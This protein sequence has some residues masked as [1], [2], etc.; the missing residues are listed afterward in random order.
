MPTW[1]KALTS[2]L[3]RKD[4]AKPLE[5]WTRDKFQCFINEEPKLADLT[6]GELRAIFLRHYGRYD[7]RDYFKRA[8][9]LYAW[10]KYYRDTPPVYELAL[11]PDTWQ[12][13]NSG[14]SQAIQIFKEEAEKLNKTCVTLWHHYVNVSVPQF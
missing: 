5:E 14:D 3:A 10:W 1:N 11:T 7:N 8:H 9:G 2:R 13:F 6:T 4:G 12:R